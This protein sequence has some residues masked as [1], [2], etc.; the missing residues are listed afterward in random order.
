MAE[1]STDELL[2][3]LEDGEHLRSG[4]ASNA[5]SSGT[6]D[7]NNNT[8]AMTGS[9]LVRRLLPVSNARQ[10]RHSP[11]PQGTTHRF[12]TTRRAGARPAP[13]G[14]T[15][16]PTASAPATDTPAGISARLSPESAS[17]LMLSAWARGLPAH[18]TIAAMG[19]YTTGS[20]GTAYRS[21][22]TAAASTSPRGVGT[23][24]PA[25]VQA[26]GDAFRIPLPASVPSGNGGGYSAPASIGDSTWRTLSGT[27]AVGAGS[28]ARV[29]S[30]GSS[31]GG[32]LRGPMS[33]P[34]RFRDY[35]R[36]EGWS[37]RDQEG[38]GH[39]DE[40][41]EG[42]VVVPDLGDRDVE[43]EVHALLAVHGIESRLGSQ[44]GGSGNGWGD[45]VARTVSADTETSAGAQT[46]QEFETYM[47][48]LNGALSESEGGGE[49][50]DVDADENVEDDE[51]DNGHDGADGEDY[52]A[53]FL[54]AL[55]SLDNGSVAFDDA[56][57]AAHR[58]YADEEAGRRARAE[59]SGGGAYADM[60]E[61]DED[62][63]DE[64]RMIVD[65]D[66][67]DERLDERED[68]YGHENEFNDLDFEYFECASRS[69]SPFA[70]SYHPHTSTHT[71]PSSSATSA[72]WS[73]R[74]YGSHAWPPSHIPPMRKAGCV[75]GASAGAYR[76]F[77][78]LDIAGLCFDPWGEKMYAAG[79]GSGKE[80][81]F[82]SSGAGGAGDESHGAGAV[83]EWS[84]RGADKRWWVDDGWM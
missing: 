47:R 32:G 49:G 4:T 31:T 73:A 36:D 24:T 17:N 59:V 53:W 71:F 14:T 13:V 41:G 27:H 56:I 29:G 23:G 64:D 81:Y 80:F 20:S 34:G 9:S 77:E 69:G 75:T 66:D 16:T 61:D 67:N 63:E 12:G 60:D 38:G 42:I 51:D 58:M 1:V 19:D 10:T 18:E 68:G 78:D 35:G 21:T 43:S 30:G 5:S 55:G 74:R 25:I 2:Q 45:G 65:E 52:H 84:V 11:T 44:A 48:T 15:V 6:A 82:G 8:G 79:V 7:A 54:R 46:V 62:D 33:P 57:G 28:L 39:S 3:A 50:D 83:V 26:L 70:G 72:P 40:F 37:N 22:S 76:Y